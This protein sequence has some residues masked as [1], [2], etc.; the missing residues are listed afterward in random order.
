MHKDI[1]VIGAGISGIAAGY[2]L[3]K[4]C[5]KK[6]FSIL[7]GRESIGG[8]WDLFKYPGIRSDS[9]MHTL[10]FRFKPWIHDKSIADGPSIMEYLHETIDEYKLKE[11]ILLNHRVASANWNSEKSLWE[12][13]IQANDEM[14]EMTCSFLFYVVDII[15]MQSLICP[16]LK[17]KKILKAKLFILSSGMSHLI[18][19]IKKL[20]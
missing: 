8:T 18:I 4:S 19:K 3:K 7:E 10:G 5:P 2:N 11:N 14:L 20:L 13:M 12:L 1:L 17:I 9:D 16:T 15:V 6:S